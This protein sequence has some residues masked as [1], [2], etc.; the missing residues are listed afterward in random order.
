MKIIKFSI[1]EKRARER[2]IVKRRGKREPKVGNE[3]GEKSIMV[4]GNFSVYFMLGEKLKAAKITLH[5][6]IVKKRNQTAG[7]GVGKHRTENI[8]PM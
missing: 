1:V 8:L 6:F 4:S 2:R 5:L 7:A 3:S